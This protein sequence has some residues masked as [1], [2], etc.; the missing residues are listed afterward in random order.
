MTEQKAYQKFSTRIDFQTNNTKILLTIKGFY[1]LTNH[2]SYNDG[3]WESIARFNTKRL[4]SLCLEL[5][6]EAINR[7]MIEYIRTGTRGDIGTQLYR[8]LK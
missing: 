8:I 1:D 7:D 3:M 6:G 4:K 2:S 5:C